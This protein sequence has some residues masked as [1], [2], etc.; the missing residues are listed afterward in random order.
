MLHTCVQVLGLGIIAGASFVKVPQILTLKASKS[1][2]G[3]SALGF[4]LE[5]IGY[6]IHAA[7]GYILGLPFSTYGEAGIMLLQNTLLLGLVYGYSGM[8][9]SRILAVAVANIAMIASV[10]SGAATRSINLIPLPDPASSVAGDAFLHEEHGAGRVSPKQAT[11]AYDFNNVIFTAARVPQI[12]KNFQVPA[13]ARTLLR[14][15]LRPH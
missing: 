1:A 6:T 14:L 15:L 11:M 9:A 7:Y 3:L 5:N 4:E 12:I 2:E 10:I 13:A 8:N